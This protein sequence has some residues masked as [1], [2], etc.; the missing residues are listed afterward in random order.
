MRRDQPAANPIR[1]QSALAAS[2][3]LPHG[4]DVWIGRY[5]VARVFQRA[6]GFAQDGGRAGTGALRSLS[7]FKLLSV[8]EKHWPFE[9]DQLLSNARSLG[10]ANNVMTWD[11]TRSIES[12]GSKFTAICDCVKSQSRP[13]DGPAFSN[14]P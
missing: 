8:Y 7:H 3:P 5:Q 13:A 9:T 4:R 6:N 12:N 2:G 14:S 10:K 11:L 1:F